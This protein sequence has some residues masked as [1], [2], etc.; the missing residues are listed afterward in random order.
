MEHTTRQEG[1]VVVLSLKGE[2]DVASAPTAMEIFQGI[3]EGGKPQLLVDLSGISFMD[4]TGLG[5]FVKVFKQLQK[6]GGSVKFACPQPLVS[7]VFTITGMN[8]L[9]P[10]FQ[11]L[12][13]GLQSYR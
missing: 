6:A 4:S 7:K 10:V 1:N 11:T 13:E 9:F 5:V 2:M 12:E 8:K 3:V